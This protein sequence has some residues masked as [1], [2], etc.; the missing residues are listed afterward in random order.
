MRPLI[1]RPDPKALTPYPAL[2]AACEGRGY[3]PM[4]VH[5]GTGW[6]LSVFE[7]DGEMLSC[8]ATTRQAPGAFMD[9]ATLTVATLYERGHLKA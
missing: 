3:R 9:L 1:D 8:H 6:K 2:C 5:S 7:Q 4:L